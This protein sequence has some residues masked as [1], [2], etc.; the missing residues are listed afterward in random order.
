[1]KYNQIDPYIYNEY[2]EYLIREQEKEL[3]INII[4][5]ICSLIPL[6]LV[7]FSLWRV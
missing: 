5:L 3:S 1:M 4:L 6:I 2:L 7:L